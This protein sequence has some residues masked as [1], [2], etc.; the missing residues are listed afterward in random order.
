MKTGELERQLRASAYRDK[1][2]RRPM[3]I[4][5]IGPIT[6]SAIPAFSPPMASFRRGRGG[7]RIQARVT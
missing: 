4:P 2:A 6:V 5:G 3:S 1:E 7:Y